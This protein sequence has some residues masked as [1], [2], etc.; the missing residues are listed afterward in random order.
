MKIIIISTLFYLFFIGC[1]DNNSSKMF[2]E[3]P[4]EFNLNG[5]RTNTKTDFKLAK[6]NIY[7]SILI[8]TTTNK[9]NILHL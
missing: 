5:V 8:I 6:L 9:K 1:K 4:N 2:K 3:F 7:D